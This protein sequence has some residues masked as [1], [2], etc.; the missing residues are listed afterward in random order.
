MLFRS[1][2]YLVFNHYNEKDRTNDGFDTWVATYNN[3][4]LIGIKKPTEFEN[5]KLSFH[6]DKDYSLIKQY[7]N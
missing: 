2:K 7:L 3:E 1:K 4:E 5:L 6:L